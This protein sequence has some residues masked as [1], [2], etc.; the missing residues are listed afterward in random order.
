M[1]L[2]NALDLLISGTVTIKRLR[3]RNTREREIE[4]KHTFLPSPK[5]FQ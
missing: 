2:R 1:E 5:P 4:D 3:V